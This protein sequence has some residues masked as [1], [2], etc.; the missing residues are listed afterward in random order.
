MKNKYI[1]ILMLFFIVLMIGANFAQAINPNLPNIG[2]WV[3]KY[4]V[5]GIVFLSILV[6]FIFYNLIKI[7][8][9]IKDNKSY[10][11]NLIMLIICIILTFF[12]PIKVE[13]APIARPNTK[14]INVYSI[15]IINV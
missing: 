14:Y 6:S 7:I 1:K 5:I 9:L 13:Y 11:K 15:I 10:K 4:L 8:K 2:G 3:E 12:I